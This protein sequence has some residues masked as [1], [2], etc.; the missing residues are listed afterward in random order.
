MRYTRDVGDGAASE[1]LYFVQYHP[2]AGDCVTDRTDYEAWLTEDLQRLAE[3]PGH[4]ETLLMPEATT[5]RIG[6]ARTCN[7]MALVQLVGHELIRWTEKP[8]LDVDRVLHLAGRIDRETRLGSSA[9][10]LVGWEPLLA[11]IPVEVLSQSLCYSVPR[12]VVAFIKRAGPGTTGRFSGRQCPSPWRAAGVGQDG[13]PVDYVIDIKQANR[14]NVGVLDMEIAVDPRSTI[15][16]H[17]EG[18]YTVTLRG[19]SGGRDVT[20]DRYALVVGQDLGW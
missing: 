1:N 18:I 3:S 8:R 11:P 19:T 4:L 6:I 10:V 9:H 13:I 20:L 14:W 7:R 2:Q 16:R 5:V 12:Q 17:G 15:S